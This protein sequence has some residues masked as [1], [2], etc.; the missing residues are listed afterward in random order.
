MTRKKADPGKALEVF[1]EVGKKLGEVFGNMSFVLAAQGAMGWMVQDEPEKASAALSRLDAE[2]LAKV[3]TA[4]RELAAMAKGDGPVQAA[5]GHSWA[6]E[7]EERD[8]DTGTQWREQELTGRSW[9]RCQCGVRVEG[10]TGEPLP[11]DDVA[12]RLQEHIDQ[13]MRP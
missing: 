3:A 4:A 12:A 7:H 6:I 1:A 8:R 5:P 11:T 13:V 10:E 2:Q 9:G